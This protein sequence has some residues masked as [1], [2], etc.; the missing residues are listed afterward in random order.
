MRFRDHE[1]RLVERSGAMIPLHRAIYLGI[2]A[3]VISRDHEA[4]ER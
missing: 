1:T 3:E 4:M 2:P